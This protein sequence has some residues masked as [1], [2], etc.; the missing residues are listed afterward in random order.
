MKILQKTVLVIAC[1]ILAS[2]MTVPESRE[3]FVDLM[4][5]ES[6]SGPFKRMAFSKSVSH[7]F[8]D[9][10]NRIDKKLNTC[11]PEGF[12]ST[13]MRSNSMSSNSVTN[14]DRIVKVSANTA[15]ITIQ[16]HHSDT[17]MQSDGGFFLLAGD[18]IGVDDGSARIDFYTSK[19][20]LN[21][22]DAIEQWANGSS[23]CHG[24]GGNP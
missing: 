23:K 3:H 7:S 6:G 16:Q 22:A 24:V 4:K 5:V 15:E 9:V 17:L 10:F 14:N 11:V 1:L 13:T 12:T 19:H 8:N 18:V 21:I 20:Y 2:C